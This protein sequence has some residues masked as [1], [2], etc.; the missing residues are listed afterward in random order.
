MYIMLFILN[1]WFAKSSYSRVLL[2]QSRWR[3]NLFPIWKN[4]NYREC[5]F[6]WYILQ[7]KIQIFLSQHLV[8]FFIEYTVLYKIKLQST[9]IRIAHSYFERNLTNE[10][11]FQLKN[12]FMVHLSLCLFLISFFFWT[13]VSFAPFVCQINRMFPYTNTL[14]LYE[15]YINTALVV[16]E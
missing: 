8:L 10:N 5:L 2:V 6:F 3:I 9:A 14:V 1:S 11:K 7:N 15:Y 16:Y 13:V 12:M 4:S